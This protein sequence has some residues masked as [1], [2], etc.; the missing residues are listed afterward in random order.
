MAKNTVNSIEDKVSIVNVGPEEIV[1]ESSVQIS[2]PVIDA[3]PPIHHTAT[4]STPAIILEPTHHKSKK[5]KRNVSAKL[6]LYLVY[7]LITDNNI[8]YA[9]PML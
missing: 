4:L 5:R 1:V 9:G 7:A 8:V 3:R 2:N 6:Q